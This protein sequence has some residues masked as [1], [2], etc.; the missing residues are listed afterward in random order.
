MNDVILTMALFHATISVA[1]RGSIAQALA[2]HPVLMMPRGPRI[3]GEGKMPVFLIFRNCQTVKESG[4]VISDL[5]ITSGNEST[6][7]LI[8]I[9][10]THSSIPGIS[11]LQRTPFRP[12]LPRHSTSP[13]HRQWGI[14]S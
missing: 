7:C 13:G 3:D 12:L 8:T 1:F 2:N 6:V 10:L 4:P 14:S 9:A 5:R 11:S